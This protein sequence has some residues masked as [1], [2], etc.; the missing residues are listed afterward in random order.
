[1]SPSFHAPKSGT[2]IF[3]CSPFAQGTFLYFNPL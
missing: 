1:L 3:G 2:A